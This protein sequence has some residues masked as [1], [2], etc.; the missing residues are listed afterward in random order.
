M[1]SRFLNDTI[2]ESRCYTIMASRCYDIASVGTGSDGDAAASARYPLVGERRDHL[3]IVDAI[4]TRPQPHHDDV[5]E[6]KH[7]VSEKSYACQTE[8]Y[9]MVESAHEMAQ[10]NRP[11]EKI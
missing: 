4:A 8:S 1:A 9:T 7:T 3:Q 2:M 5:A 6:E 10:N 11:L